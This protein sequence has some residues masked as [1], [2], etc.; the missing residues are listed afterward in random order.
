LLTEA[1]EQALEF[2]PGT[3][4][5][6]RRALRNVGPNPSVFVGG[7]HELLLDLGNQDV[8]R[9][10]F[11]HAFGE[12]QDVVPHP[13]RGDFIGGKRFM[14]AVKDSDADEDIGATVQQIVSPK[15]R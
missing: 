9:Y 14:R 6:P 13:I 3:R 8:A 1:I 5:Q 10:D 2:Y 7:P 12:F 15:P 4:P 11:W